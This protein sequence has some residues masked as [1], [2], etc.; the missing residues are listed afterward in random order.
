MKIRYYKPKAITGKIK[1]T[2][3]RNG[4]MGFSRQAIKKL[5]LDINRY[6]K[7]GFN[8]EDEND[9]ALYL[10]I[11]GHQDEDTYKINKAGEYYYL[12]TKYIFDDLNIDYVRKKIIYDIQEVEIDEEVVYKLNKREL[13]RKKSKPS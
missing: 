2:I 9:R 4:K 10:K 5:G 11:Q 3:H 12:N 13:A 8:E 1:C 7:I 6:A